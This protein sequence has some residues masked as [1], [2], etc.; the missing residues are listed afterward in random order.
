MNT[1]TTSFTHIQLRDCEPLLL[2]PQLHSPLLRLPRELRDNIYGHTLADLT[3]TKLDFRHIDLALPQPLTLAATCQLFHSE[4]K[5]ALHVHAVALIRQLMSTTIIYP[6]TQHAWAADLPLKGRL[7]VIC[8]PTN[9]TLL[10]ASC[11]L[12][13]G[14]AE[15]RQ[16]LGCRIVPC[17]CRVGRIPP[18]TRHERGCVVYGFEGR[19]RPDVRREA[20]EVV[21]ARVVEARALEAKVPATLWRKGH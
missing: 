19:C 14:A 4:L 1:L 7:C 11:H 16:V 20:V 13:A 9:Y 18:P 21:K 6:F 12:Y 17:A 8:E 3:I 2:N 15:S 5:E 10:D